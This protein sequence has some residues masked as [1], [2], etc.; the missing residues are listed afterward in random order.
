MNWLFEN[1]PSWLI[2]NDIMIENNHL[3]YYLGSFGI[4]VPMIIH[5]WLVF[6][7]LLQAH[8]LHIY[9]TWWR[10]IDI[11]T[12]FYLENCHHNNV[13]ISINDIVALL[14][15]SICNIYSLFFYMRV[16]IP[17]RVCLLTSFVTDIL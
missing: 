1:K 14:I 11:H 10:P 16:S 5:T 8:E 2:I 7:P 15:I 6:L 17:L 12:N 3:H 9:L 13:N 4:G